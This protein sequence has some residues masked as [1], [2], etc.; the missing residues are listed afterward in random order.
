M[1]MKPFFFTFSCVFFLPFLLISSPLLAQ[2]YEDEN[3]LQVWFF[4]VGQE[5]GLY[6]SIGDST[7]IRNQYSG[8][9]L[10]IDAGPDQNE[11][12]LI[13]SLERAG[14]SSSNPLDYIICTSWDLDH[15]GGFQALYNEGFIDLS[16][17]VAYD[18]GGGIGSWWD[19]N[20]GPIRHTPPGYGFPE[21]LPGEVIDLGYGPFGPVTATVI[22]TDWYCLGHADRLFTSGDD[23]SRSVSVVVTYNGFDLWVGGDLTG[24]SPNPDM[25]T[26]AGAAV[27]TVLGGSGRDVDVYEC[28]HHGSN[29]SSRTSFLNYLKPDWTVVSVHGDFGEFPTQ[30]VLNR[31]CNAGCKGIYQTGPGTLEPRTVTCPEG[32]RKAKANYGDPNR[33]I[34]LTTNGCEYYFYSEKDDGTGNSTFTSTPDISS[35]LQEVDVPGPVKCSEERGLFLMKADKGYDYNL[36]LY[37]DLHVG[38]TTYWDAIT[39]NPS[40]IARDLWVIPGGNDTIGMTLVAMKDADGRDINA[41]AVMKNQGGD[42]N[43]YLYNTIVA[44]DWSYWDAISRNP[45]PIARD[46]WIIPQGDNTSLLTRTDLDGDT[47]D[48]LAVMKNYGWK[49]KL[50]VYNTPVVGDWTYWDAFM[51]NWNGEIRQNYRAMD[52]W[53]IPRSS[54]VVAMGGMRAVKTGE[55]SWGEGLVTVESDGGNQKLYVWKVP[56][57]L[58]LPQSM[59][60]MQNSQKQFGTNPWTGAPAVGSPQG[61]DLWIVPQRNDIRTLA[62]VAVESLSGESADSYDVIGVVGDLSSDSNLWFWKTVQIGDWTYNHALLRQDG[63]PRLIREDIPNYGQPQARDFWI[64]PSGNNVRHFAAIPSTAPLPTPTPTDRANFDWDPPFNPDPDTPVQFNDLSVTTE[65]PFISWSWTFDDGS[66]PDSSLQNPECSFTLDD[67]PQWDK[68]VTLTVE[69]TGGNTLMTTKT[70]TLSGAP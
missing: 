64:L 54:N 8:K 53:Y 22:T 23:N 66:P 26:P 6:I 12:I 62:G 15:S 10:L 25:E 17:T 42:Q 41:L 57:A 46:L 50:F 2:D 20:L 36:Y 28:D 9:T 59:W 48:E 35:G 40:P 55:T 19:S 43:I 5:S 27:A 65:P 11:V 4:L 63:Y 61:Q 14:V 30:D 1:K 29:T 7:L 67:P 60:Q 34:V 68:S 56:P 32:W 45:S 49:Q 70:V 24:Y 18:H 44:D 33:N 52:E 13:D 16:S 58:W 37:N 47:I 3:A 51:R 21:Y 31:C 38:D 39:R 69:D